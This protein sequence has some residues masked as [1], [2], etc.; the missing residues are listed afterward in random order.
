MRHN[1]RKIEKT[2]TRVFCCECHQFYDTPKQCLEC[3][4]W[5]VCIPCL[6]KEHEETV[7]VLTSRGITLTENQR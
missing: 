1:R 2:T 4:N 7:R 6:D 3:S 5:N